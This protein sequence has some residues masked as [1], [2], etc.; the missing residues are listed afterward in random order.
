V[1]DLPLI[2]HHFFI[3]QTCHWSQH[4]LLSFH[5]HS[6]SVGISQPFVVDVF[7]ESAWVP[8]EVG[9]NDAF[10]GLWIG[11]V[12]DL[13]GASSVSAEDE[14]RLKF[15][16]AWFLLGNDDFTH[17]QHRLINLRVVV[18]ELLSFFEVTHA[19]VNVKLV[20]EI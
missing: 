17:L 6:Y 8:L 20:E 11:L 1:R 12:F 5:R 10:V 2:V 14:V 19:L 18:E 3:L 13:L 7:P 16:S 4:S 15:D 9:L